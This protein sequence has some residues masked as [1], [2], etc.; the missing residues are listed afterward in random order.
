MYITLTELRYAVSVAKEKHF[1]KAAA[2][3]FVSQPTLSIA[4]KKLEDSLGTTIF[5]R[6]KNKVLITDIGREIIV[7]A[8]KILENVNDLQNYA[9]QKNNI[10]E[11]PVKIGAIN[12]VGPYLFPQL[13][14]NLKQYNS[15]IKLIIEEGFTNNLAYKLQNGELDAIIVAKP[16]IQNHLEYQD[17]YSEP[18][19]II[20]PKNHQLAKSKINI[21]PQELA[22]QTILLLDNGNCFRDQVLQICPQCNLSNI[23]QDSTMITT[24]SIETIKYMVSSN[25]GISII[26]RH[27]IR[28]NDKNLFKI[29]HFTKPQPQREIIIAYRSSFSRK[30]LISEIVLLIQN[31]RKSINSFLK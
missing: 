31:L 12:T 3:N 2:K 30:S 22:D 20:T 16:F 23:D 27:S 19:D 13:I 6:D 11:Q 1:A 14:T 25:I 24:S 9:K 18:L 21:K 15:Q 10:Y 4:I 28:P 26:P 5:E 8:Q 29:K 17:L 7:Q